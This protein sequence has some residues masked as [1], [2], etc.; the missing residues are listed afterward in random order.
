M[1][2]YNKIRFVWEVKLLKQYLNLS[3][4]NQVPIEIIYL[5]KCGEFS[6]RK[7]LVRRISKEKVVA[8]CYL[9]NQIR[10]FSLD[11][12]LSASW[13]KKIKVS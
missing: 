11:Q 9:R 3:L 5:S 7:V 10:S 4:E 13:S 6:Q 12:I 2:L 1:F 8:Y